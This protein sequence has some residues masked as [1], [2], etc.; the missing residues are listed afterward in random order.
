MFLWTRTW[1]KVS[2][3]EMTKMILVQKIGL[4]WKWK[5]CRRDSGFKQIRLM[6]DG[7]DSSSGSTDEGLHL[8]PTGHKQFSKKCCCINVPLKTRKFQ[9]KRV[10][11]AQR[12]T[13]VAAGWEPHF[14]QFNDLACQT[15]GGK[16][17]PAESNPG[18][19]IQ[20]RPEV[21]DPRT[22]IWYEVISKH[23]TNISRARKRNGRD[24]N[25]LRK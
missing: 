16:V 22:G 6:I 21:T 20:T 9:T 15:V 2:H 18:L 1:L 24:R 19:G 23:N 5:H 17:S 8:R 13:S 7:I 14:L 25:L 10:I 11:M 4:N 3:I 12:G